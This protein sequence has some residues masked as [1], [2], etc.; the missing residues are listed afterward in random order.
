MLAM[1]AGASLL[2]SCDPLDFTIDQAIPEQMIQGSAV[3]AVLSGVFAIPLNVNIS[4]QIAAQATGTIHS[5]TIDDLE[6]DITKTDEPTGDTDDWSFITHVTVTL[7][8]T[9]TGTTLPAVTI[10]TVDGSASQKLIFTVDSTIDVKPYIDEGG[11]IDAPGS[12]TQPTDDV[13][14]NGTATFTV[15][16]L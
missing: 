5:V 11:E 9:K 1:C 6:L 3:P 13:S 10:G 8:S 4:S 15:H 2:T 12:G 7:K 14:Y 16:T